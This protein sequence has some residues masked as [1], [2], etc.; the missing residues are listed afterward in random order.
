MCFYS[1][2]SQQRTTTSGVFA[3]DDITTPMHSVI[4]AMASGQVAGAAA[5]SEL[6]QE[7]FYFL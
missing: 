3:A 2:D 1:V 4:A 6:V 7:D 5:A